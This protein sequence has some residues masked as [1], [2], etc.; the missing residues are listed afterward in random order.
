MVSNDHITAFG[1]ITDVEIRTISILTD[2]VPYDNLATRLLIENGEV[3]RICDIKTIKTYKPKIR[4]LFQG[5]AT[6]SHDK[7]ITVDTSKSFSPG[8]MIVFSHSES[9]PETR[10]WASFAKYVPGETNT[11]WITTTKFENLVAEKT[12]F[13]SPSNE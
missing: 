4:I 13:L 10:L 3:S 6:V 2:E 12:R 7:I 8:F 5:Y 11:D 1:Y 9:I